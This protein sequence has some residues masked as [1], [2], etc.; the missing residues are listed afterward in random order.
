M[1]GLN[2][3]RLAMILAGTTTFGTQGAVEFACRQNALA[4]HLPLRLSVA[5]T[6]EPKPFEAVLHDTQL[7]ALRERTP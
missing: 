2:P 7:V 6:G 5:P 4:D 3:S 1:R